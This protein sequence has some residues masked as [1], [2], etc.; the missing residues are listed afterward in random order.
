MCMRKRER[1][2]ARE[3]HMHLNFAG[4]LG[5][6]H[7]KAMSLPEDGIEGFTKHFGL[8]R[9]VAQ[10][11]LHERIATTLTQM[12]LTSRCPSVYVLYK[13][14]CVKDFQEYRPPFARLPRSCPCPLAGGYGTP[15]CVCV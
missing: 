4:G 3:V 8:H 14:H 1:A 5:F 7:K 11:E 13:A 10:E 15:V 2:R 6:R 9:L 12:I